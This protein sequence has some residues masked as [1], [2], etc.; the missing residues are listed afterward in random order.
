[1]EGLENRKVAV[2]VLMKVEEGG[3]NSFFLSLFDHVFLPP[4]FPPGSAGARVKFGVIRYSS[5][6]FT[7]GE[8]VDYP[9]C[10][11]T[12]NAAL[13]FLFPHRHRSLFFV[14]FLL[15]PLWWH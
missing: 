8:Y 13:L 6:F 11:S 10:I 15:F 1:M 7:G 4:F 3:S 5:E 14:Y 12:E 2:V 9:T